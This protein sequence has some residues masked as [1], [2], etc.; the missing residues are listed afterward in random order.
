MTDTETT[1][2]FVL[3]ERRGHILIASLNRPERLNAVGQGMEAELGRVLREAG[4][5]HEIRAIVL[6]AEGRAFCA[7]GD[8]ASQAEVEEAA[9]RQLGHGVVMRER[10]HLLVQSM[11]RMDKPL[12]AMING[13]AVAGGLTL[14]LLC[15]F[16]VAAWS[17]RLGDTSGRAG[18]LPDE[19]GAWLFPRVMGIAAAT[20]M[21]LLSELY[22]ASTA[23]QL[24]LVGEVVPDEQLHERTVQLADELAARAPLAVRV[25]KR[26]MRRSLEL[27]FEQSLGDAEYAVNIVNDSEDVQ[28]GVAAFLEKRAPVFRGR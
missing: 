10:M 16:R 2:P 17:A 19:G 15:D 24:G 8:V 28:E 18:L 1:V 9:R 23:Q 12:I 13:P 27:T 6:R 14:A 21:T 26:M 25:A 5:D 20:R 11:Y 22:D 3:T 7:G 4:S